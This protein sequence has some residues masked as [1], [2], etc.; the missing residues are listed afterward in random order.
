M[1]EYHHEQRSGYESGSHQETSS[2]NQNQQKYQ[3]GGNSGG[4]GGRK[5]SSPYAGKPGGQSGGGRRFGGGSGGPRDQ[6]PRD[7]SVDPPE[8][9]RP[10]TVGSNKEVSADVIQ[11]AVEVRDMLAKNGYMTRCSVFEGLDQT[12]MTAKRSEIILPWKDFNGHHSKLT[13]TV[14]EAKWFAAK[15]H[16]AYERLPDA[17]KT[18][19][20]KDIRLLCGNN[21]KSLV[22]FLLVHSDDGC[23]GNATRGRETGNVGFMIG[24]ADDLRIP[25]FNFAKPNLKERLMKHLRIPPELV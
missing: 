3:S 25:I 13:F 6:A 12:F 19:L 23:E 4:G 2:S 15:I 1:S 22:Q 14:E 10:Y 5:W 8:L 20:A 21:L 9:Y 16:P 17:I 18:F 11:Q 24:V 7:F